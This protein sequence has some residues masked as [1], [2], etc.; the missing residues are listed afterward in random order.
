MGRNAVADGACRP[1]D[2]RSQPSRTAYGAPPQSS[3]LNYPVGCNTARQQ[4]D[5]T[6]NWWRRLAASRLLDAG[7]V[8][9]TLLLLPRWVAILPTRWCDYDFNHY[10]VGSRMLLAGQNPYTTSL[11][12]MSQALGFTYSSQLPIA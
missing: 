4:D 9:V 5:P 1:K 11:K 7:A 8:V 2:V 3:T 6:M 10:Y 12:A